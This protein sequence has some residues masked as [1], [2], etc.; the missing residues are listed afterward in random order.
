M[1]PFTRSGWSRARNPFRQSAVPRAQNPQS[2]WGCYSTGVNRACCQTSWNGQDY[3]VCGY[4]APGTK[5]SIGAIRHEIAHQGL[6]QNPDG[7]CHWE[8]HWLCC[9]YGCDASGACYVHCLPFRTPPGNSPITSP[10][11][12]VSAVRR[13]ID[14]FGIGS[15]ESPE[16]IATIVREINLDPERSMML[17][18]ALRQGHV[19]RSRVQTSM[20]QSNPAPTCDPASCK[21]V[22][23]P[24]PTPTDPHDQYCY[25]VPKE[26]QLEGAYFTQTPPPSRLGLRA[27]MRRRRIAL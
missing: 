5:P 22:C 17:A 26:A 23:L 25:R 10:A 18:H 12:L 11:T 24:M 19:T 4:V 21:W 1:N 27:A 14:R 9:T 8:G 6:R 20:R 2:G 15:L 13:A 7:D 3:K 16:V